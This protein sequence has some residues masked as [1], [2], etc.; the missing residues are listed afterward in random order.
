MNDDDD[1]DDDDDDEI[2]NHP[3]EKAKKLWCYKR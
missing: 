3:V 1:D 2:E